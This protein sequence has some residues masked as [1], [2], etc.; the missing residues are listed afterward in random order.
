M[1]MLHSIIIGCISPLLIPMLVAV[2]LG[3]SVQAVHPFHVCVAQMEWNGTSQLWEVSIR[4]HPQDL[5]RVLSQKRGKPTSIED[6][7]FP[8]LVIPFL[9]QQFA[10][11][12]APKSMSIQDLIAAIDRK[13]SLPTSELRWVGMEPERGWLWIHLE[14]TPPKE[15]AGQSWLLHR[16]FLDQIDRQENSVR[17][18]DGTNR[19]ALQF[20]RGQEAQP[21][22]GPGADSKDSPR[23]QPPEN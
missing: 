9:D 20:K 13:E 1:R 8:E 10:I 23:T 4:V 21:M 22:K 16:I 2:L 11:V 6:R 3:P 19:Y 15:T 17:I 5:E 14:M 12:D 18:V 7:D